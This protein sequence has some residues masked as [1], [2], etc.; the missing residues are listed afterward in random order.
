MRQEIANA[1]HGYLHDQGWNVNIT[2]GKV[3]FVVLTTD[4]QIIPINLDTAENEELLVV[5]TKEKSIGGTIRSC[6][7]D[8][9][10]ANPKAFILLDEYIGCVKYGDVEE[11]YAN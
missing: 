6:S 11:A 9:E 7:Y 2:K 3:T 5:Y 4:G 1:I 10:L 8:I